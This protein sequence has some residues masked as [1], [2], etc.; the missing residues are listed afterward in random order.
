VLKVIKDYIKTKPRVYDAINAL[1]PIASEA[2]VWLNHYSKLNHGT[3]KFIQVG[4]NDGLRGDP[5]R[6]FI[7]RDNWSGVL[8]EPLLPVYL[9]LKDNYA[10]VKKGPLFFEN[11]AISDSPLD[12]IELWSFAETFL[13]S[14]SVE[15]Q[16]NYLRKS[17]LH[18]EQIM[19]CFPEGGDVEHKIKCYKTR[20]QPLCA[21]IDRYFSAQPIDLI[22]IDA[23]G[24]D[25]HIIKTIDFGRCKPRAIFYESHNLGSRSEELN[26]FLTKQGYRLTQ[27]G[28]DAVATI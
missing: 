11:C 25:D 27:L 9:M 5:V 2:G 6:R 17:S 10:H 14:L 18:K 4:A 15:D 8:V 19:H 21:L 20:C 12:Y 16:M 26:A 22:F 7:L 23:E 28:G 1:R 13:G 24:H 3:V